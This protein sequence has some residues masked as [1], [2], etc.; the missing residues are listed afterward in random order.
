MRMMR[1]RCSATGMNSLGSIQLPS[2]WGQRISASMPITAPGVDALL[3]LVVQRESLVLDRLAQLRLERERAE[4][5]LR[6]ALVEELVV[7]AAALL[8]EIHRGIAFL[9]SSS[10]VAPSRG[11]TPMPID[12]LTET[13]CPSS[14]I[15]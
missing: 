10:E 1:P 2:A 9:M 4:G 8:G 14:V 3:R 7:A 13:I 11:K 12:G 6:E 15:G 5:R